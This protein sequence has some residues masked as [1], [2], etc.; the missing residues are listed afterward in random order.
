[1][2]R[3]SPGSP[4][5]GRNP[6]DETIYKPKE[7]L[8]DRWPSGSMPVYEEEQPFDQVWLWALMGFELVIMMIAL[9]ASGQPL[10]SAAV[11]FGAITLSMALL[12]SIRLRTRIDSEGVHYRFKPF[13]FKWQTIPWDDIDQI[14]VRKY[15]PILEYGGWG[16]RYSRN[17]KAYNI[18]GN[19]GIQ[20]VRKNGKRILI[21]TRRPEEVAA[22]LSRHPLLV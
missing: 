16:I 9:F 3:Y 2:T 14:Q 21:G 6:F 1:M 11:G 5:E 22:Q 18:R 12:S 8:F 17:G 7:G 4:E 19:M 15:S 10:W 20:I 13:H